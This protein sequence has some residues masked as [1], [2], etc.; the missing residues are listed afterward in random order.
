MG[1][2]QSPLKEEDPGATSHPR[3]KRTKEQPVTLGRRGPR[4][5][6]TPLEQEPQPLP[7]TQEHPDT[8]GSRDELSEEVPIYIIVLTIVY[9]VP[10]Y[11]IVLTIVYQVPI[12]SIVLTIVYQVPIYST[13]LTIVYQVPIYSIVLTIVYQVPI[14]SIVLTIVWCIFCPHMCIAYIPAAYGCQKKAPEPQESDGC[15][16]TDFK[17]T[18]VSRPKKIGV[19][20]DSQT[21]TA[22]TDRFTLEEGFCCT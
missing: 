1:S 9:Q 7:R 21:V 6:Q 14:Y 16:K 13:V 19:H 4:N 8:I 22:C 2:S 17:E 15:V 20:M 3:R 11:S 10:I 18:V 5:T 12:Y